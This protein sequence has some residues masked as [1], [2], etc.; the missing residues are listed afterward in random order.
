M[1]NNDEQVA[2]LMAGDGAITKHLPGR[3]MAVEIKKKRLKIGKSKVPSAFWLQL[4]VFR[5]RFLQEY[6]IGKR[7]SV[8]I[9]VSNPPFEFAMS[10]LRVAFEMIK[11]SKDGRV[12]ML[13]PTSYFTEIRL[14]ELENIGLC[15]ESQGHVGRWN[16]YAR[17]AGSIAKNDPDSIFILK[18]KVSPVVLPWHRFMVSLGEFAPHPF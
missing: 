17:Q 16:Y 11:W 10:T 14:E 8:K 7:N 4:D 6:A 12:I 3:V 13:L 18:K 9:V 15:V 5:R 2:E 1:D